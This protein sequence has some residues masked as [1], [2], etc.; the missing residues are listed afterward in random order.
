MSDDLLII[1][2]CKHGGYI[3]KKHDVINN[4]TAM[5]FAG[6]L[7]DCFDFVCSWFEGKKDE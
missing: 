7:D 5:L 6:T 1:F 2:R 3:V 4:D